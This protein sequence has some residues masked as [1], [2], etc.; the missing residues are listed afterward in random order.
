MEDIFDM[1][2]EIMYQLEDVEA[3]LNGLFCEESLR[4]DYSEMLE[5]I[6]EARCNIEDA[7]AI[8]A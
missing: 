6:G 4:D 7:A 3:E 2:E 5:L 1:L 8:A